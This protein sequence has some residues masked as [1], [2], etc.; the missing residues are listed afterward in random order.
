LVAPSPDTAA[1]LPVTEAL[2]AVGFVPCDCR[3]TVGRA[4]KISAMEIAQKALGTILGA[5]FIVFAVKS[6]KMKNSPPQTDDSTPY[7]PWQLR[8]IFTGVSKLPTGAP[9]TAQ[10][11]LPAVGQDELRRVLMKHLAANIRPEFLQFVVHSVIQN[12]KTKGGRIAR[13]RPI[14]RYVVHI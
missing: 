12:Q 7:A 4:R 14:L 1:I 10:E 8:D 9:N 2:R 13:S 11:P 5:I 3:A 6:P